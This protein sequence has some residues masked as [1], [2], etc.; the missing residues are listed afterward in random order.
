MTIQ[1]KQNTG[2]STLCSTDRSELTMAPRQREELIFFHGKKPCCLTHHASRTIYLIDHRSLSWHETRFAALARW[3]TETP[4][5]TT[6]QI[7]FRKKNQK[8]VR[9]GECYVPAHGQLLNGFEL[10][11]T[12]GYPCHY[13][14]Q[15]V[16]G[17]LHFSILLVASCTAFWQ[18]SA[19]C[20]FSP[21]I[22]APHFLLWPLPNHPPM[23]LLF[24]SLLRAGR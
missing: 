24:V 4:Q 3:S 13:L 9:R 20:F 12:S 10:H 23:F 16:G 6:A 1:T 21:S 19:H 15:H 8:H 17:V 11:F 22:P 5:E 2:W 7:N 14:R 18:L